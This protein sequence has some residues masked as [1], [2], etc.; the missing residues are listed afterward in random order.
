MTFLVLHKQSPVHHIDVVAMVASVREALSSIE[1]DY[2]HQ[3]VILRRMSDVREDVA[4][5]HRTRSGWVPLVTMIFYEKCQL[6]M[7]KNKDEAT[8]K[9]VKISNLQ[10]RLRKL[11]AARRK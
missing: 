5:F 8:R 3:I 6:A 10:S 1:R 4:E 2:P 9:S 7:E 11:R